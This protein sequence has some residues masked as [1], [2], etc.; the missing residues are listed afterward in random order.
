[1]F[2]FDRPKKTNVNEKRNNNKWNELGSVESCVSIS[3]IWFSSGRE[4]LIC[5]PLCSISH[6]W[7]ELQIGSRHR[8]DRFGFRTCF[9]NPIRV[10]CVVQSFSDCV[11]HIPIACDLVCFFL[12]PIARQS[13]S[14]HLPVFLMS[15][16]LLCPPLQ[17]FS[18]A[19]QFICKIIFRS[20]QLNC[21]RSVF[22]QFLQ[23][24]SEIV[25]VESQWNLR[26][27]YTFWNRISD[28]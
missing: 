1:M 14:G 2:K 19:I 8:Y 21:L 17:F 12:L 3:W 16:L 5:W 20:H 18:V 13:S 28:V 27:S 26:K 10:K 15:L 25:G 9:A 23:S 11:A 4:S 22:F 6:S 24:V 7:N